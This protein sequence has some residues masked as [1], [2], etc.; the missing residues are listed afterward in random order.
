MAVASAGP[1][2]LCTLLQTDNH[3]S[4]SSLYFL[5]ARCSSWHPTNSN[6]AMKAWIHT[7]KNTL[8]RF[9]KETTQTSGRLLL[10]IY[11]KKK[12]SSV[13]MYRVTQAT[14][15]QRQTDVSGCERMAKLLQ[16][17]QVDGSVVFARWRQCVLAS[18]AG[19]IWIFQIR[20]DSVFNLKY[21]VSVFSVSV[22]AH[23]HIARVS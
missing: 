15:H 20:F 1:H 21:S 23:H 12:Q 19:S 4:T 11:N 9:K 18:K 5:Q 14:S 3:A 7:A 16:L 17:T 13:N 8:L 6:K 22:F 2:A 10:F